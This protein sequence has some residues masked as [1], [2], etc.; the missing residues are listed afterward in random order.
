[1]DIALRLHQ[2]APGAEY[3]G[4]LTA[5]TQEAYDALVWLDT[6]YD[7]PSWETILATTEVAPLPE[8][9][10][11][12][13]DTLPLAAKAAFSLTRFAVKNELEEGNYDVAR[14]LISITTVPEE[15]ETLKQELLAEFDT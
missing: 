1:M 9:L 8:R 2:L 7:K 5:N 3:Q 6:T 13:F 11:T 14:E 10:L 15:L 12:L 4:S